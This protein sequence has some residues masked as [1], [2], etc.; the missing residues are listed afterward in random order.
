MSL[1]CDWS[2]EE[3]RESAQQG[4]PYNG[5]SI[6]DYLPDLPFLQIFI[7]TRPT[8]TPRSNTQKSTIFHEKLI[9]ESK[10]ENQESH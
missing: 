9:M 2:K 3:A 4:S 1:L 8:G 6:V 5:C 10:M 7:M